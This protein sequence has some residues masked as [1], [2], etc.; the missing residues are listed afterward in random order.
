MTPEQ[1][2]AAN[3]GLSAQWRDGFSA[4]WPARRPRD[5]SIFSFPF[6]RWAFSHL[7]EL[8]PTRA[9]SRGTGPV[10]VLPRAERDELATLAFAR[11]ADGAPTDWQTALA[12]IHADGALV[13]H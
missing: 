3:V 6:N 2:I 9:V 8:Q 5:A 1:A 12:A 7:P 13:L 10:A 4:E 11:L